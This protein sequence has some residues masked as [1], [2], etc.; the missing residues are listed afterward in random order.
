M[1]QIF[2]FLAAVLLTASTYAQVGIGTTIPNP[3]AALDIT[4]TTK[5]LLTPRMT[6]A[7]RNAISSPATGLIVWCSNCG[8]SGELQV[9][10]GTTWTNVI[11]GTAS[12][13]PIPLTTQVASNGSGG[14]YTF[15]NHNL[16]ADVSLDPH[17]P[18][19]GLQGGHIQWGKSGPANWLGAANDGPNG[20]AAAPTLGNANAGAVSS[21][22]TTAAAN[23]SWGATKTA[24]DPCPTGYRVPTMAEWINVDSN[25]TRIRTG[26]FTDNS[27]EYGSALH[28]GPNASIKALTLPSAGYRD[29]SNGSLINRGGTGVYWSSTENS[30]N[31]LLYNF[32]N[33]YVLPATA[34]PRTYAFS[35]RCIAE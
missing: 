5:G 21:W 31:S 29:S 17:V 20:F 1:K 13:V 24:N 30:S 18:A 33:S 16:G 23:G 14:T 26:T 28:Y 8:N 3:S 27:T 11:G 12:A 32:Y 7:Q 22:S 10:N 6:Q 35:I 19:V 2:T 25:N 34:L 15:L 4:S 9:Y